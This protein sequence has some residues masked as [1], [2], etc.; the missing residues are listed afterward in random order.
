M[1]PPGRGSTRTFDVLLGAAIV[2][3]IAML[4]IAGWSFLHNTLSFMGA[5]GVVGFASVM[6]GILLWATL[7]SRNG[8][9]GEGGPSRIRAKTR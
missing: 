5:L 8:F 3:L 7:R 6:V 9:E 1:P 2:L 4:S